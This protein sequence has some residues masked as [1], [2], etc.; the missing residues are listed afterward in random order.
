MAAVLNVPWFHFTCR[1]QVVSDVE[2]EKDGFHNITAQ[3]KRNN[4]LTHPSFNLSM[5]S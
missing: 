5:T 2:D 4:D 3:A 1:W